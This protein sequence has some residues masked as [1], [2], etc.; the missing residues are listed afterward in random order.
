[1][2][3]LEITNYDCVIV[4]AGLAGLIAGRNLN[5]AGHKL[6][7]L[8][9]Q[10]EIGGRMNGKYVAPDQYIDLGGQWV[11]PTQDRFLALLDEYQIAR[12]PSPLQGKT[13]LV[14]NGQRFEFKGF[15]QGYPQS[16]N[17]GVNQ[18]EWEDAIEG[19][20]RFN[21]L[22]QTI[23]TGHPTRNPQNLL[24]DSKTFAQWIEENTKTDF[25]HWYF[26]YKIRAVGFLG[27]AE[28]GQVSLLHVLWGNRC[29]S[30]SESPEAELIHDGAGQI[31]AKIAAEL[32]NPIHTGEAVVGISQDDH[33]VEVTTL[34]AT[35][36][37]KYAI[38]AMPPH[39]A[40]RIVYDPPL[41]PK[42][43][44]LTQRF[45]MGTVAKILISYE[46][47]FWREKG[48]AGV[49]MGNCEWIEL[50]ADSSDPRSGKGVIAT[51]LVGDRY[52][53]W[54]TLNES[55]RRSAVLTDLS[56]YLGQE[57]LSPNTFDV[58]DWPSNQW[59]GGGYAAFMPPGVWTSFG[60]TIA[61]PVGRIYW[62]GSEIAERW[63]GFFDGAV[64]TAEAA[65]EAVRNLL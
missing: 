58:K 65:A 39:L 19:W 59:V 14:Y 55:E 44:Q 10:D 32:D 22:S 63:P 7:V 57:A 29:A 48:L 17:P 2:S 31:P 35:Y 50:F 47:P 60:D 30:Q 40:G 36:R 62:A 37:A 26:S 6:L 11:G 51:F 28:P 12:F 46:T 34:K 24:L 9:A 5:R 4:G 13:V 33:G 52:Y 8:E 16:E 25:A 54:Q 41:P 18:E 1:M 23:D 15:F 27:P 3:K 61:T 53:R 64:C 43:Q 49:G 20:H 42:R 45:P 38:V 56:F 21:E